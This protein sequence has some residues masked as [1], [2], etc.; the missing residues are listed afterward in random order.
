MRKNKLSFVMLILLC[1][2]L[3]SCG[4]KVESYTKENHKEFADALYSYTTGEKEDFVGIELRKKEDYITRHL[5]GFVLYDDSLH[6]EGDFQTWLLTIASKNTMIFIV[7]DDVDDMM[8]KV[9]V[10]KNIGYKKIASYL[11]DYSYFIEQE[12]SSF[13][14]STGLDDCGC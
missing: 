13:L 12:Q 11:G 10:A 4:Q 9:E 14:F 8:K 6:Q 3:V 7:A 2:M 5:S 1:F